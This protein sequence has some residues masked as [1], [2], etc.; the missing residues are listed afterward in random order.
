MDKFNKLARSVRKLD[1]KW[2]GKVFDLACAENERDQIKA[3]GKKV[4]VSLQ[5]RI[6]NFRDEIDEIS[7]EYYAKLE[8]SDTIYH[9][10]TSRAVWDGSDMAEYIWAIRK[11]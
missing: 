11:R 5:S 3:A 1:I 4:P 6:R 8:A 10:R 7:A 9:A 2:K